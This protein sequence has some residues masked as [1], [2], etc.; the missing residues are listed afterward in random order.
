VL[1]CCVVQDEVRAQGVIDA[2]SLFE[3]F[4]ID[5]QM[6]PLVETSRM[7][8]AIATVQVYVQRCFLGLE[9]DVDPS[10]LNSQQWDWMSRFQVWVANRKV[11]L[12]PENWIDP[13]LRDDKS[14]FFSTLEDS[15]QQKD[16]TQDVI[17]SAIRGFLY[18]VNEVANMEITALCVE[19]VGHG[20]IST[21]EVSTS[22]TTTTTTT[23]KTT[24]PNATSK[25]TSGT[26]TEPLIIQKSSTTN[27]TTKIHL[28]ARTT[29]SPFS[30]YYIN[31][32]LGNWT[33]WMKMDIDI[34]YYTS[35]DTSGTSIG[36]GNYMSPIVFAGR[37]LVFVPQITKKTSADPAQ[38]SL[39]PTEAATVANNLLGPIEQWEIQMSKWFDSLKLLDSLLLSC[40]SVHC[41]LL[42][43]VISV[44][45]ALN[46]LKHIL[47]MK[48]TNVGISLGYT[49]LR[50][51]KWMQRQ[52]CSEAVLVNNEPP[53][54][55][56]KNGK[57]TAPQTI[58]GIENFSFITAEIMTPDPTF[59]ATKDSSQPVPEIPIGV[60]VIASR[61]VSG[62]PQAQFVGIGEW[63]FV[64]GKLS[65]FGPGKQDPSASVSP[66][67]PAPN[68]STL[69][70]LVEAIDMNFGYQRRET[71]N[72]TTIRSLTA[73]DDRSGTSGP[74]LDSFDDEPMVAKGIVESDTASASTKEIF[75]RNDFDPVSFTSTPK[76]QLLY[77]KFIHPLMIS[78]S[79]DGTDSMP[80]LPLYS[81]LGGF[82]GFDSTS[83][84]P[85]GT[86]TTIQI[87]PNTGKPLDTEG[88]ITT[89]MPPISDL[90]E[91]FGGIVSPANNFTTG[92]FNELSNPYS[93]YNWEIGL[94]APMLLIDRLLTMQQFDQALDVCQYVFNPNLPKDPN[95]PKNYWIFAPFQ[96]VAT[97]TT[98]QM[99]LNFSSLQF[100][101]VCSFPP[102][103]SRSDTNWSFSISRQDVTNWRNN[104]FQPH[105]VARSRPQ[106]YMM[107]IVMKY[108]EILIAYG[109]YYFRQNSLETI[110]NA[111]Q[112]Y[113][114]ASHL[115]G[116]RGQI[117]PR[118]NPTKKY[119]YNDLSTRF[120]A[121][122]NVMV[123][124]E[125]AF[126][127]S[128]Q[129]PL[130]VGKL[131]DNSSAPP[132]NVFGFAGTLLF[133][134][135]DNPNLI[136]LGSTIDDRL[137]KIRNSQ[138][139]N[140]VFRELPLFDP[141]I[142]PA[143]LVQ[144]VA[145]G[146]SISSVLQDLNGPMPNYRFQYLLSKALDLASDVKAFGSA[147]LSTREKIDFEN[148]SLLR[149]KHDTTSSTL[150][151]DMKKLA[152]DEANST[153]A[154]LQY[155]RNAPVS[156]LG[157]YL[158][159]IGA[160][161][162]GIPTVNQEF[163]ELSANIDKPVAVGGLQLMPAEKVEMDQYALSAELSI[164]AGNLEMIGAAMNMMPNFSANFEPLGCGGSSMFGGSNVGAY[165]QALARS[166]STT[167]GEATYNAST[168]GRKAQ[169]QRAM[170]DRILQAN[171]AG[172]EIS[173]IDKQVTANKIR[174]AL[175][176]KDIDVQQ[177]QID[178]AKEVEDFLRQK[179]SNVDLYSWMEGA[180]RSLFYN[181]YTQAYDLAKKAEKAFQFERPAMQSTTF[182]QS[183]Y[184]DS[185]H[186]GL[187]AGENLF[188]AL[189]QL[190][191]AYLTNKGYDYEITKSVSLRQLD[192]LQLIT[193]R[194]T[195]V[196]NFD[197]PEVLF[198][199]DFPGHYMRRLKSVSV[200]VPCVVGPYASINSTLRLKGHTTR[201]QPTR[202]SGSSYPQVMDPGSDPDNRFTTSNVP[203]MA[204]AVCNGQNDTGTFELNFHDDRYLP[205]EGAGAISSW[206]FSL[207]QHPDS[208]FKQ[209]NWESITDVVMTLRYTSID[210]GSQMI[211]GA[212]MAVKTYL[213]V[214]NSLSSTQGLWAIFD[215]KNEFATSWAKFVSD[216]AATTSGGSAP[217]ASLDMPSLNEKLPVFASSRPRGAVQASDI[218][219][220]SDAAF[221]GSSPALSA[222]GKSAGDADLKSDP[223]VPAVMKSCIWSGTDVAV[224]NWKLTLDSGSVGTPVAVKRAWLLFRYTLKNS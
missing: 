56:P 158:Q 99:F 80:L 84:I 159:Q 48:I 206:N 130:P 57:P 216:Q 173:S 54:T 86:V 181:I 62:V 208:G 90:D 140:G 94:H 220:L 145:Q 71:S 17:T 132:A 53:I 35:Q 44:I 161:L 202:P 95:S 176:S 109:D 115:Y 221:P 190:E 149:A 224:G 122:S 196:C 204:I 155:S 185:T 20:I 162:S 163:A 85:K 118:P 96:T 200:S 138:D 60:R 201:Y 19:K 165:Y 111:I 11:F 215:L 167:V 131:P 4:L 184:W 124:L 9:K 18:S 16:L 34:P 194:Q 188:S 107:W 6:T 97:Q 50:D 76:T 116:P 101:Y 64:D 222:D 183:G 133:A 26:T 127:F 125:E 119:T 198:D 8:Q 87:D 112:M 103:L 197:I 45:S 31:Y 73:T 24:N 114:L 67:S 187:F 25:V 36:I 88:S 180:T 207:P 203:I 13:T 179:Y 78:A 146:V 79:V 30:Y 38:A 46:S 75:F 128:N 193:L 199:M 12:Y 192:P 68:I 82:T 52:L 41:I 72:T 23:T 171:M 15:L 219:I 105:V 182:I 104:P 40:P 169:A 175:A 205:F 70:T 33:A 156:R 217:A 209:F 213:Q 172:Y 150:L 113:I 135:P 195:G 21:K 218:Y 153:L 110:P 141:P 137:F 126:P 117:I 58:R 7:K 178:Q 22:T 27:Y 89:R 5:V 152:L 42:K 98:E 14:P 211:G 139:I 142:D 92:I 129:T 69:K 148:L 61:F 143:L 63:D 74:Q 212:Q 93:I 191:A 151:M 136:A 65:F 28:F 223:D 144:A 91:A 166:A 77:H 29:T 47:G 177:N 154:A 160:D 55:P 134:I 2:D 157:Y 39:T 102:L 81:C 120:D 123:Q 106:A 3:F 121:F 214:V 1:T 59:N 210:G 83:T 164:N 43:E 100:M 147:L 37:L 108:I 174:I 10:M 66:T 32:S 189:K 168:A 170:Q 186:D 49:E 51:G